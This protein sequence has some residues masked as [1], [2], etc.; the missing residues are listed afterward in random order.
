MKRL[1]L[2]ATIIDPETGQIDNARFVQQNDLPAIREDHVKIFTQGIASIRNA[3]LTLTQQNVLLY[4]IEHCNYENFALVP[5]T[6]IAKALDITPP[7]VSRAT[8]ALT[9][10]RLITQGAKVGRT[11]SWKLNPFNSWKGGRP[12]D[13]ARARSTHL[14][15]VR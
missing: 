8:K 3:K 4:L 1:A 15:V 2:N 12:K 5:N 10:K 14:Q 11:T 9:E 7:E 13:L 6:E